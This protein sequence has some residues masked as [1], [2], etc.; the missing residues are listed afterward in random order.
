[1]VRIEVVE[2]PKK[3]ET[4]PQFKTT[5]LSFTVME[6]DRIGHLVCILRAEDKDSKRL[7]FDITGM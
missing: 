5:E 7:W 2:R 3:S 4:P 1:M 6:N